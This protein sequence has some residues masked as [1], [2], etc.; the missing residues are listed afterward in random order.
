MPLMKNRDSQPGSF[1]TRF[2]FS[3]PN[4]EIDPEGQEREGPD[5]DRAEEQRLQL[6]DQRRAME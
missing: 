4:F 1:V 3:P 6:A 2:E 5:E